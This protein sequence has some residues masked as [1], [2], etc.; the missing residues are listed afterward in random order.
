MAKSKIE[1]PKTAESLKK[2][3]DEPPSLA[4]MQAKLDEKESKIDEYENILKGD[5]QI[6]NVM[7]LKVL[8]EARRHV[9]DNVRLIQ[10][11]NRLKQDVKDGDET[12]SMLIDNYED[13]MRILRNTIFNDSKLLKTENLQKEK[14]IEKIS[15]R[16]DK[17]VKYFKSELARQEKRFA[18]LLK[19]KE[20]EYEKMVEDERERHEK[21]LLDQEFEIKEKDTYYPLLFESQREQ[22]EKDIEDKKNELD[23]IRFENQSLKEEVIK[24]KNLAFEQEREYEENLKQIIGEFKKRFREFDAVLDLNQD[25]FKPRTSRML[26]EMRETSENL[27]S[28]ERMT[29]INNMI[30]NA[31]SNNYS[32][33]NIKK[34]LLNSG[35]TSEEIEKS[36]K[37]NRN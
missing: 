7:L 12:E 23:M 13:Q 28:P 15:G 26:S 21:R 22:L 33:E 5:L 37:E 6:D 2:K 25:L 31:L 19:Q 14:D 4:E 29:E 32:F 36:I 9:K 11:N 24:L 8:D 3:L 30:E 27:A 18:Q 20:Q 35:Y 10:E 1:V 17:T 16:F 34:S